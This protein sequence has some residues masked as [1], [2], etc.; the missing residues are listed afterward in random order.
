MTV[1][2]GVPVAASNNSVGMSSSPPS[3]TSGHDK[4][5]E[6]LSVMS[7]AMTVVSE[8]DLRAMHQRIDAFF[9]TFNVM[10]A[11]SESINSPCATPTQRD[12]CWSI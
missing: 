5:I 8:S 12:Y 6:A 3:F 2:P 1:N 9:R 11:S 7:N 10:P 4:G